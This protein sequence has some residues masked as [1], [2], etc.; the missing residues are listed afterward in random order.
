MIKEDDYTAEE[1]ST[2]TT[3]DRCNQPVD[4]SLTWYEGDTDEI[5]CPACG[6]KEE[7]A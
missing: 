2:I 3:C 5:I 7:D 4:I 1:L 6:C